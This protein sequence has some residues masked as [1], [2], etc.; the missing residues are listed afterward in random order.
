[1]K[2]YSRVLALTL[3]SVA[4]IATSGCDSGPPTGDVSGTVTM[5]GQPVTNAIVTFVPQHGGQNAIG[6]T[7]GSGKYE[8]YRRGDRGALLGPH[9]VVIATV[10]EPAAPTQEIS[11]DSEEYLK[12]ATS[13]NL[14][15]YNR[16]IVHEPIPARYNKQST[17]TA[18]VNKGQNT[19]DFELTS[20]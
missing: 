14:S 18:E 15:D 4:L 19:F 10:Q 3:C 1:M 11:S 5:D 13:S 8:L 9:S 17:L 2:L 7:D 6:K 20:K 16:A 12:Q